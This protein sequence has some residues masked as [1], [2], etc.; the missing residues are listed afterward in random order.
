MK[1]HLPIVPPTTT[2]QSKKIVR[3][4]G[5]SKLAD[6]D[7]LKAAIASYEGLLLQGR[8]K[9]R[10]IGPIALDI[11]FV[12]PHKKSTPKKHLGEMI[13]K[14]AK[15]DCDNLSKTLTDAMTRTFWFKDDA[16][17]F[18]L[19]VSKYHG[20]DDRVGVWIDIKGAA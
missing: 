16:E 13:P 20:P 8:P 15:P 18:S 12:W 6:T 14:V 19:T 17:I 11:T 9:E 2:H 7:K 5:F 4:G 3:F 1:L 10:I